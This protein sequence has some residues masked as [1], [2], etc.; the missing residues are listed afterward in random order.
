MF[1]LKKKKTHTK[2][3]KIFRLLPLI[4]VSSFIL[5]IF[6]SFI[7]WLTLLLHFDE[8]LISLDTVIHMGHP[9]ATIMMDTEPPH[10]SPEEIFS[11][12][13]PLIIGKVIQQKAIA[14]TSAQWYASWSERLLAGSQFFPVSPKYSIERWWMSWNLTHRMEFRLS[15]QE[16]VL[17]TS[18]ASSEMLRHQSAWQISLPVGTVW[19]RWHT[20]NF[21][22]QVFLS[23]DHQTGASA[24]WDLLVWTVR[25]QNRSAGDADMWQLIWYDST[26]IYS[27]DTTVRKVRLCI[28][29]W[30]LLGL[31]S[32]SSFCLG[33]YAALKS[34][35]FTSTVS[36]MLLSLL[37]KAWVRLWLVSGFFVIKENYSF[38]Y[39]RLRWA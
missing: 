23:K 29:V 10:H 27:A 20:H 9:F 4:L 12:S 25:G 15:P 19:F 35:H 30:S 11:D 33:P 34:V 24:G 17:K 14:F 13:V 22:M 2:V 38:F 28:P 37:F 26:V 39:K 18:F 6:L 1:Y 32:D 5:I 16:V 31:A 21:H 7:L 8:C 36:P 3:I